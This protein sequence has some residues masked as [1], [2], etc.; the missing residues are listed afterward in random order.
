MPWRSWR[1][2]NRHYRVAWVDAIHGHDK[3]V[4]AGAAPGILNENAIRSALAR[5][6][7]GYHRFIHEKAAALVHGIVSNHGFADGNK[8][9]ALYL[10]E[11]M[12]RRSGYEFVEDDMVIADTITAVAA[13]QMDYK[14]L[15]RWFRER[16]VRAEGA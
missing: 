10:V 15:A 14:A 9:T 8:R 6:Y 13:G 2:A 16:I 5:P 12:L 1:I 3:A 7:H 11:L 4:R